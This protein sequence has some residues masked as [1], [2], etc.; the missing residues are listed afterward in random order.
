MDAYDRD[1]KN[2]LATGTLLTV[3][4]Q[5]DPTTGTSRLKAV[6]ANTDSALFPNQ[7]VNCRLLLDTKHGAV[8]V[9]PPPFSAARK[10]PTSTWSTGR[11]SAAMRP[12]PLGITEGDN[13]EID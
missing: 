1:D 11:Q 4:N 3:D 13:V 9:P 7:F 10:A 5:I 8:I 6:F 2:K 12:S